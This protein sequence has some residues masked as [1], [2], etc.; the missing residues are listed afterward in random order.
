[1]GLCLLRCDKSLDRIMEGTPARIPKPKRYKI[2]R[3]C[4]AVSPAK[5]NLLTSNGIRI[6]FFYNEVIYEHSRLAQTIA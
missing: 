5:L 1:M 6:F 4:E 3:N 2:G